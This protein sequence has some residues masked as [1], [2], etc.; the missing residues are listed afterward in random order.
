MSN[1]YISLKRRDV[2]GCFNLL[3]QNTNPSLLVP[4]FNLCLETL[5]K[6]ACDYLLA[7]NYYILDF[8]DESSIILAIKYYLL[9]DNVD[10]ALNLFIENATNL[11]KRPL[12]LILKHLI[13]KGQDVQDLV[14]KYLIDYGIEIYDLYYLLPLGSYIL[15]KLIDK[16]YIVDS[17]YL[18][19]FEI[20]EE[21]EV[22][23]KL[24]KYRLENPEYYIQ[25]IAQIHN[26]KEF[27]IFLDWLKDKNYDC[28]I[29]GG[30]VLYSYQGRVTETGY[31]RLKDLANEVKNPLIILHKKYYRAD[32]KGLVF[33]TPYGMN[34]DVFLLAAGLSGK[35][36]LTNDNFRDH[37]YEIFE[38]Q[39][40]IRL[41]IKDY[42]VKIKY[43]SDIQLQEKKEWSCVVQKD[44]K[45][46]YLP[47]IDN[48]WILVEI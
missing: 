6:T 15:E 18:P 31:K 47:T 3:S 33:K 48:R 19:G 40:A 24:Y 46:F 17:K 20:K 41:W 34:D 42:V 36:V 32:L 45:Y 13:Q 8:T 30:N 22:K 4:L 37:I 21:D 43:E 16:E 12:V 25:K 35:Y 39:A 10:K 7:Q 44:D 23:N 2:Q 27:F 26:G 5:N 11:R 38:D 1:F 9:G 28:V 29:D 14:F